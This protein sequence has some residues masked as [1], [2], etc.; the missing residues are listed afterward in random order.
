MLTVRSSRTAGRGRIIARFDGIDDRTEAER[1][2]NVALFAAPIDDPSAL[3]VHEMIGLAVVDRD[4]T[5]RGIC[6]AV[7]DNPAS[8]LIELDTGD[9]VPATFVTAIS[10]GV[11]GIDAPPGLFELRTSDASAPGD[12][13]TG[14]V[15]PG[16]AAA[17][18]SEQAGPELG[19]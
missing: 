17:E 13:D 9:L 6:V 7:L 1:W 14:A 16:G 15:D 19:R 4:G 10:D 3:W 18:G 5:E 12:H 8:E 11:I 2:T